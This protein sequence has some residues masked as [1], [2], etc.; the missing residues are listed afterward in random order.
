MPAD[1]AACAAPAEASAANSSGSRVAARISA[2]F[3]VLAG[4]QRLV[5]DHPLALVGA[6]RDRVDDA[7]VAV[8]VDQLDVVGVAGDVAQRE[9][10]A[11]GGDRLLAELVRTPFLGVDRAQ[12]EIEDR[13]LRVVA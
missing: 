1:G 13:P 8:L 10:A 11:A 9:G 5:G 7:L 4:E 3:G 6:E 12:V 2:S